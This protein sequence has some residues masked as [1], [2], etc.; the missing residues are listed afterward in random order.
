MNRIVAFICAAIVL[1][2]AGCNVD[3]LSTELS[4]TRSILSD[5][6]SNNPAVNETL[7]GLGAT[8]DGV[9]TAVA[10]L[11]TAEGTADFAG[12]VTRM[13]VGLLLGGGG[14]GTLLTRKIG[15]EKIKSFNAGTN[16]G[17]AIGNG[18]ASTPGA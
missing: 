1:T 10:Q 18:S 2:A 13:M 7:D 14:I 4:K 16:N 12:D 3:R 17:I 6:Q 11:E 9:A 5:V 8:L 15:V